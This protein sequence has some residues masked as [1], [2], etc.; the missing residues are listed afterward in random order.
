M[1]KLGV[2]VH[3]LIP[4][5]AGDLCE[6]KANLVYIVTIQP[7][8]RSETLTQKTMIEKYGI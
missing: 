6:L 3:V 2:V 5:E 8:L 4:A 7:E 1:N